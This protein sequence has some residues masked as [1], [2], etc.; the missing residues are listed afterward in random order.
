MLILKRTDATSGGCKGERNAHKIYVLADRTAATQLSIS[1][2]T[3][4]S[5]CNQILQIL[6][7]TPLDVVLTDRAADTQ[8]SIPNKILA[9]SYNQILDSNHVACVIIM[10][11][12]IDTGL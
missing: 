5:S 1:N 12:A 3:L 7:L 9:S 4:A 6:D 8:L 11:P 10:L 2:K